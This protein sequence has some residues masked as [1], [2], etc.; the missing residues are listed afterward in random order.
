MTLEERT[1]LAVLYDLYSGLLTE[2]QQ[3]VFDLYYQCDLSLGE[4]AAEQ[5]ISR[6]AVHDLIKR[7]EHLLEKYEDKLHLAQREL[8]RRKLLN[9]LAALADGN[10]VMLT[11]LEQLGWEANE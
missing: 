5:N 11:L 2:K 6:T 1:R 3:T 8:E 10:N 4:I 9:Q 7:T